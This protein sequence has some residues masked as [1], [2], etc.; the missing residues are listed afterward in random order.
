MSQPPSSPTV[1]LTIQ[2]EIIWNENETTVSFH[3]NIKNDI[4]LPDGITSLNQSLF[5]FP[6]SITSIQLPSTLFPKLSEI[7]QKTFHFKQRS[8]TECFSLSYSTN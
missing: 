2:R 6:E 5:P 7:L 8:S 4:L 3:F 1:G